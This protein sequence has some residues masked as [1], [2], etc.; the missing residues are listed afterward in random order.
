MGTNLS[1]TRDEK[2]F[3]NVLLEPGANWKSML[4]ST[5]HEH[6]LRA[7]SCEAHMFDTNIAH[8]YA[9]MVCHRYEHACS[10]YYFQFFILLRRMK[11]WKQSP[12]ISKLFRN[13]RHYCRQCSTENH[14]FS[15][16][17][18]VFDIYKCAYEQDIYKKVQRI[19]KMNRN[20]WQVKRCQRSSKKLYKYDRQQ[21]FVL[22]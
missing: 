21:C 20:R 4:A 16:A 9:H 18:A 12:V 2:D 1:P 22:C 11:N 6:M 8:E 19:N 3:K 17:C 13:A 15:N 5:A 7:W 14:K 10:S